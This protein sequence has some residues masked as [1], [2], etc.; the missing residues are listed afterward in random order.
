MHTKAWGKAAPVPVYCCLCFPG[1]ISSTALPPSP[2]RLCASPGVSIRCEK[3][4]PCA[5]ARLS[6]FFPGTALR[7]S[8]LSLHTLL[9][10]LAA[11]SLFHLDELALWERTQ[12]SHSGGFSGSSSYCLLLLLI[13]QGA[14]IWSSHL[15]FS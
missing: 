12:W 6:P 14:L 2:G 8:T 11:A 9:F 13:A 15:V 10:L 5:R 1:L 3:A 7:H 4:Q